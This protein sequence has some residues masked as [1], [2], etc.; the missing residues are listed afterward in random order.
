M[1][2]FSNPPEQSESP[3][4]IEQRKLLREFCL[5]N[6]LTILREEKFNGIIAVVV[7]N[8]F[9]NNEEVHIG[10]PD[11]IKYGLASTDKINGIKMGMYGHGVWR[12][13]ILK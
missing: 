8:G 11:G 12:R 6:N 2:K 4:T 9:E 10:Y 7:N 13:S 1:E 3:A 5:E